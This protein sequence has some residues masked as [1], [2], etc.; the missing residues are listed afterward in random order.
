[1]RGFYLFLAA[2]SLGLALPQEG[3][4]DDG[5][6]P[7]PHPEGPSAAA[8]ASIYVSPAGNDGRAG[9]LTEPLRT[10]AKAR[11]VVR[12]R[13]RGGT[14]VTTVWLRGGTYYL[15]EPV[16]FGQDDSGEEGRPI[17]YRNYEGEEPLLA[18]GVPVTRWRSHRGRVLKAYVP[19]IKTTDPMAFQVIED[20]KAGTLARTPNTGWFRLRDPQIEPFWSFGCEA[21]D[22]N[23]AGLDTASLYVHLIQVGTYFS[24]HI[25]VERVDLAQRRFYT[26]FKMPDAAY[27]PIDGKSYLVENALG[28]LDA[29]GEFYADRATGW[30]YYLPLAER[31]AGARIVADTAAGL[32]DVHGQTAQTPVH[33]LVFEGLRF[34][35]G[36][37]QITVANA[38][39][40]A[41]RDCRLLQ[42]SGTA[43]SIVAA[44]THVSVSGCEIAYCGNNGVLIQGEYEKQGTGP[45]KVLN[46]HQVIENNYIHHVGRRTISGCGIMLSGSAND[47]LIAHN[48]VTDS[49][50]SG[51][52]MFS[53]WDLPRALEVM[54]NNVI[55]NNALARCVTSSWDGGAFYIGAT[56]DNTLFENNRIADVW[57]WFNATWP[58][59]EDRPVDACSIDFDPGLTFNTRL[60]N[61]VCSGA[62]ACT[63]EFGRYSDETL[64]ENNYFESPDRPGEILNNGN[65]EKCAAFS[66]SKVAEDVGLTA[67]FKFPYPKE[68]A[69]P[70]TL[71]FHCGFEG[72]LSP[73]FL[74]HYGDGLRQ[75]YFAH[76]AVHDGATALRIDN[77]VM[78]VRY[79]HPV[80][81]SKK[82]TVWFNDDPGKRQASCLAVLRGPAAIEEAAVALGV[83][84]AVS[85]DH[86]V[87]QT[88][89]DRISPTPL[90]RKAGWHEL[91]FDVKPEKGRGCELRLD[92]Q[93][94][95]RVPMFQAFTTIDLGDGQF[96]TDSIGLGFD[97]V[98]VE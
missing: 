74:Y 6:R 27:N 22:L 66:P 47:N 39:R 13:R 69:R 80:P 43:L 94:V 34:L 45:A 44:S 65:W 62:N 5:G 59:P 2:A 67:A 81:L 86:Y 31:P 70:I 33:D 83:D 28:L 51:I 46:H 50:K 96:G 41:L 60:H 30:L 14:P 9:T 90:R 84:G 72:T 85:K 35:G 55:R 89:C 61:N 19:S 36:N 10:L 38:Q 29:P 20:G 98:V 24:E 68:M 1:M 18:G 76:K 54:N 75:D 40:V 7:L 26:K 4:S 49:P 53:A 17:T 73:F 92:G 23:L 11:D 8:S 78:V 25:R 56:T 93:V 97:S 79:R 42:A 3:M 21:G 71:P 48:L 64:L 91:V 77:D 87:V 15:E 57:S 32:L 82:V 63:V 88:W 37:E 95:G 12:E 52:L 58:Q 16:R